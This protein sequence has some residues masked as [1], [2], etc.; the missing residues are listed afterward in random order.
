MC[1]MRLH[2]QKAFEAVPNTGG[3]VEIS[4][5]GECDI[6]P[7][8]NN[9]SHIRSYITYFYVDVLTH[10]FPSMHIHSLITYI[11]SYVYIL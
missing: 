1:C 5:T 10:P 6:D 9:V 2:K 11:D 8:P 4:F 3:T 7:R